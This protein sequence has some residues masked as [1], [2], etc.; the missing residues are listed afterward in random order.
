MAE[1][2]TFSTPF[3]GSV[4]ISTLSFAFAP[5][6]RTKP[7]GTTTISELPTLINFCFI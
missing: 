2:F 7:A 6:I 3:V 1:N 5:T 4:S